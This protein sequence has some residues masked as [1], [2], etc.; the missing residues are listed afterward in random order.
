ML[1]KLYNNDDVY[2][3]DSAGF[4]KQTSSSPIQLCQLFDKPLQDLKIINLPY[5]AQNSGD[6]DV[7]SIANLPENCFA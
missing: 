5:Q 2:I 7:H 6:C 4:K 1:C 3:I